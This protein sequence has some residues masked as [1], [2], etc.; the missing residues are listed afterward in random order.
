MAGNVN[1]D[2][3][4]ALARFNADGTLDT[5][6]GTPGVVVLESLAGLANGPMIVV[7]GIDASA[8]T[9]AFYLTRIWL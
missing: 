1:G 8:A 6:F 3:T 9:D 5:S 4:P 7:V 2:T